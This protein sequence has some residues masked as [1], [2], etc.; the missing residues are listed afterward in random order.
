MEEALTFHSDF[1]TL[2][3]SHSCG[4]VLFLGNHTAGRDDDLDERTGICV[5]QPQFP[6]KLFGALSHSCQANAH[7]TGSHLRN[8]GT[9]SIAIVTNRYHH[10]IILSTQRNPSLTCFRMPEDVGEGLLNDAKDCSFQIAR[11]SWEIRRQYL[12]PISSSNGGCKRWVA[13]PLK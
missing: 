8:L 10:L 2:N 11:E 5:G 12:S 1:T 13:H 4:G 6:T 7:A 9:D 3:T